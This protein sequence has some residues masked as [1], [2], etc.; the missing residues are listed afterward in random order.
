VAG[1]LAMQQSVTFDAVT[2]RGASASKVGSSRIGRSGGSLVPDY[3]AEV[4]YYQ[5]LLSIG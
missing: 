4:G 3:Y 1:S 5:A 2:D